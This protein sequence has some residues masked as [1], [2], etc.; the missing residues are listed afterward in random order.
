M[1]RHRLLFILLVFVIAVFLFLI[2]CVID[3]FLLM[4][5]LW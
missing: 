2:Y 1:P 3:F 5:H 4:A